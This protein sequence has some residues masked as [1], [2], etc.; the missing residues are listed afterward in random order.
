MFTEDDCATKVLP[1]LS[2]SLLDKEKIVRD[3]ANRAFDAYVSRVRKHAST[4]PDTV[5]PPPGQS[6]STSSTQPRMSTPAATDAASQAASW[7]GWAISSFTASAKDASG[8]LHPTQ[9]PVTSL[10][11]GRVPHAPASAT[12]KPLAP[13][14]R[15]STSASTDASRQPSRSATPTAEES[16]ATATAIAEDFDADAWGEMGDLDDDAA[17]DADAVAPSP[18]P[19][20]RTP[21]APRAPA[22][23]AASA[24]GEPDFAA[25]L[26]AKKQPAASK[27]LPKGL[28]KK[29]GAAGVSARPAVGRAST[30]EAARKV[31]VK[32]EKAVEDEA[33]GDAWE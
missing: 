18:V 27:A 21:A 10:S 9:P 19:S 7:A 33:W 5:L 17:A 29:Q 3:Q 2:P 24:G 15:S 13:A 28:G 31:E 1:A 16:L 11:N 23:P 4:M 20:T 12:S 26:A 30:T 6:S 14:H 32:E 22:A 8:T 25:W